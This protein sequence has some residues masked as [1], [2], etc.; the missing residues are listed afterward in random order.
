MWL[1]ILA[2]VVG[3]PIAFLLACML[4]NCFGPKWDAEEYRKE[5]YYTPVDGGPDDD[6]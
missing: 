6:D 4:A 2:G 5:H 3:A 1:Y